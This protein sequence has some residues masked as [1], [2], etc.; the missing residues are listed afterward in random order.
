[1]SNNHQ[2]NLYTCKQVKEIDNRAIN[3]ANIAGIRLMKRAAESAFTEILKRWREPEEIVVLCGGGNNG[4]DGYIVAGLAAQKNI[5]VRVYF[6]SDPQRL[7]G[8]AK[9]AYQFALEAGVTPVAAQQLTLEDNPNILI[10]DAIVGT[11]FRGEMRNADVL[12]HVNDS[13]SPVISLDLPS[14]LDGDT[15]AASGA[16]ICAD[17]TVSF[18]GLKRGLYTG[19][20]PAVRGELCFSSLG[21]PQGIVEKTL[22]TVSLIRSPRALSPRTK[23]AHKGDF[24]H[25]LV[26]GGDSGMGGAALLAAESAMRSGAGLVS[27]AT[28]KEHVSPAL[29]RLPEVMSRGVHS[30]VELE[31]L[32]DNANVLVLGPGLGRSAWS[33]QLLHVALTSH[34]P[35]VVDADA[36]NLIAEMDTS[37][38]VDKPWV[39][40]PHPGEAARLLKISSAEVQA[41]RFGAVNAIKAKFPGATVVLKG[42]GSL[43][44]DANKTFVA[45]VGNPGMAVAG[46]GDVLSGVIGALLA[47]GLSPL[48]AA[49]LGVHVHGESADKAVELAGET[50]MLASDIIPFIRECL[51]TR[52]VPAYSRAC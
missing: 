17:L 20:G 42:A 41:D 48:E 23:D 2:L 29:V 13:Q 50:G 40:T 35:C 18:V 7:A 39:M 21:I 49:T 19:R 36:L 14:G 16:V 11:G 37:G 22:S 1:M 3:E 15:G 44:A 4:G 24:G 26:V 45:N 43:I 46:M 33:R 9:R 27:I 32:L 10:V 30:G 51:N 38:L 34:L 12:R 52:A 28:R 47:R 8:D 5:P 25:V 31:P 6:F